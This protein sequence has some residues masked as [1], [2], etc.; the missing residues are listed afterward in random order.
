MTKLP[1]GTLIELSKHAPMGSALC[2][3]IMALAIWSLLTAHTCTAQVAKAI[4]ASGSLNKRRETFKWD[5]PVYVYGDDI[6]LHSDFADSAS[7][8]LESVGLKVNTNKS[9]VRSLFRESCGGEY[10]NGWDVTPVRLRTLPEN[11]VPSRMK[12]IAFHNNMFM[13]YH[14]QPRWLT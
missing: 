2:F 10:Y 6:I 3:P 5:K 8:V 4:R 12:V 11:D 9:F 7:Q 1:D 13:R 14:F